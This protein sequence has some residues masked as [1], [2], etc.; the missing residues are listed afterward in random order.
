MEEKDLA[1]S[2]VVCKLCIKEFDPS[3]FGGTTMCEDCCSLSHF[4][5]QLLITLNG[6]HESLV[7]IVDKQ[8]G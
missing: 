1:K 6:I 2:L 8:N 5:R 7:L 4:K 3:T